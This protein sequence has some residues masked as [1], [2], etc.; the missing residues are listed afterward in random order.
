MMRTG[1]NPKSKL[2]NEDLIAQAPLKVHTSFGDGGDGRY[3]WNVD[4][5]SAANLRAVKLSDSWRQRLQGAPCFRLNYSCNGSGSIVDFVP[6]LGFQGY[7]FQH[8]GTVSTYDVHLV[9]FTQ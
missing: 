1:H 9:S 4:E 3:Q 8:F 2:A 5:R 7:Y 6:G